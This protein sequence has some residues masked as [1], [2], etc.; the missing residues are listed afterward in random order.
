MVSPCAIVP[1]PD[2]RGVYVNR[3]SAVPDIALTEVS[4]AFKMDNPS[5]IAL[6]LRTKDGSVNNQ[7][8]AQDTA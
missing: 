8:V 7:S 4:V 3:L 2:S 6:P 1:Q 5:A